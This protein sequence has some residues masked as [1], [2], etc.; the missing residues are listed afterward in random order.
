VAES[1]W[2]IEKEESAAH[3]FRLNNPECTV[4]TEDCNELLKLVMSVCPYCF[5]LDKMTNGNR[6]IEERLLPFRS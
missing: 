6:C 2:A 5:V 1:C 3:A 4:F